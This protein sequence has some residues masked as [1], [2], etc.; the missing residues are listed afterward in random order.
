MSKIK[1]YFYLL[2]KMLS[3]IVL[4]VFKNK[5]AQKLCRRTQCVYIIYYI[6]GIE[7]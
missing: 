7:I 2:H 3:T 5:R 4:I 6:G 1:M